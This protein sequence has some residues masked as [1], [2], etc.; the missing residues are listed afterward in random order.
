MEN[1][2]IL[3]LVLLT[4]L[5]YSCQKEELSPRTNPRFSVAFIQDIDEDGVQFAAN[6]YDFGS[7]DILEYGFVYSQGANPTYEYAEIIKETGK[8]GDFF[9]MSA[10]HSMVK[11][12]EYTVV[13][14][15][16]TTA[17]I[18]YSDRFKF[19]SK[20]SHG[21]I[22]EKMELPQQVYFGDT[23]TVYGKNFSRVA[24]NYSIW[25][26]DSNAKITE[27]KDDYF[28]FILPG[29]FQVNSFSNEPE[30]V[31]FLIK[32]AEKS[33]LINEMVEFRR[34]LITPSPIQVKNF[35]ETVTIQGDYL[36]YLNAEIEYVNERS[37]VRYSLP[38]FE[39][40]KNE[41]SFELKAPFIEQLPKIVL[42]IKAEEFVLTNL[43]NINPSELE[44]GQEFEIFSWDDIIVKTI[45][46][47]LHYHFYNSFIGDLPESIINT[48]QIQGNNISLFFDG[49]YNPLGR[50]MKIYLNNV[51]I[52]SQN[53]M[54]VKFKDASLPFILVPESF[55]PGYGGANRGV[56]VNDIGYFFIDKSVFKLNPETKEF[57]FVTGNGQSPL[58][59]A[60]IFAVSGPNGKIYTASR[61][62]F[63]NPGNPEFFEF[64]TRSERL[65]K[66]ENIPATST[67]PLAVFATDK[68]LY[69]D[70]GFSYSEGFGYTEINDRWR[71]DFEKKIW[72]KFEGI[73]KTDPFIRRYIPFWYQGELYLLGQE[74]E[75]TVGVSLMKFD[76]VTE[77]YPRIKELNPGGIPRSNEIFVF[78]DN[79]YLLTVSGI[80][81]VN[82]ITLEENYVSN[83]VG[84][85]IG[86]YNF[87]LSFQSGDK[88]YIYNN[89]GLIREFD[90]EYFTY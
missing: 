4:I 88:F 46:P 31:E 44:P 70:G 32:I 10:R 49:Q 79:L 28:R 19:I 13:A 24:E 34:P 17:G 50:Q 64:D 63:N 36:G 15:I 83:S 48:S 73:I 14:F 20:G 5:F 35:D 1:K 43:V 69:Y 59:L 16:K 39:S 77:S 76:P 65:V 74:Y 45:N 18:T 55:Q 30:Q 87:E 27:V 22:F 67:Y 60:S 78:K 56:T 53:S 38:I 58:D 71:Y 68:Y 81:R 72:E 75:G 42:K 85:N 37:G 6:V 25:V 8:P 21:F 41:I 52:K 9:E 62:I 26:R 66:L 84:F 33:I 7:D 51:G 2:Y 89:S 86:S 82:M 11:G 29:P 3:S 54:T 40:T 57:V 23:V 12:K 61:N 80:L 90:P 47:N